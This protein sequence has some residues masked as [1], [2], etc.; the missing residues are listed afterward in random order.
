MF[1]KLFLEDLRA[2]CNFNNYPYSLIG[3]IIMFLIYGEYRRL[4][5]FRLKTSDSP[6]LKFLRVFTYFS[7]KSMNLY[8]S[9]YG[10]EYGKKSVIAGGLVFQHG[11]STI[12]FCRSMGRDCV[13]NQQVT[14]GESGGGIPTI[15]NNV[16]I[17]AGAKVLG[18]ITVGDDVIIGANA[19]VVK[20]VPSHSIVVGVPATIIKKRSSIYEEWTRVSCNETNY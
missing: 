1:K 18:N 3:F 12:I 7:S 8:I 20:D 15:G 13:V 14:V 5:D 17:Y 4:L 6:L 19:V 9:D 2:W 16:R 10:G 11:F